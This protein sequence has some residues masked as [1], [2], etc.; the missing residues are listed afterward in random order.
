[1]N[2]NELQCISFKQCNSYMNIPVIKKVKQHLFYIMHINVLLDN[3]VNIEL[4]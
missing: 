1:M 2:Y 3:A 4:F